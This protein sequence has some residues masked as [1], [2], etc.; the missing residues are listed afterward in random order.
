MRKQILI[1]A[2]GSA[3]FASTLAAQAATTLY[4]HIHM[5]WDRLDNGDTVERSFLSSNSTRVG[6]KG[7]EELGSGL[8]A[9]WQI[10]SG[11]LGVDDSDVTTGFGGDLRNSF[12]GFTNNSWG[13]VRVGRHDTPYK[14]LGRRL[15]N[16]NEQ[17]GDARNV[18]G[19]SLFDL[20]PKNMVR[21]D[22]PTFSGL[23]FSLLNSSNNGNELAAAT[24]RV[25]SL[26][27][28]WSAGPL[29]LGAAYET[30]SLASTLSDEEKGIRLA[31]SYALGDLLLGVLYE[32]LDDILVANTAGTITTA[33]DQTNYGLFASYKMGN[34][35]LKFHWI[36]SPDLKSC[37]FSCDGTSATLMAIGVDHVM[38]KTVTTYVNYAKTKNDPNA[39]LPVAS[40]NGGHGEVVP[41]VFGS[42]P[43]GFSAGVILK[44]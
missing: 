2:V 18:I 7:D 31:A 32:K 43:T 21:Y 3:I 33:A 6:L 25:S 29:F 5:S 10:E 4:G 40:T 23:T 22:S 12:L 16:F 36:D 13:T 41:G 15:D 8:K 24:Q 30:H 20:R 38:S 14:D 19:L 28:N 27:A 34:N 1:A 17:V 37:S 35:R 44:F 39:A 11:A 42:D 9:I 26:G